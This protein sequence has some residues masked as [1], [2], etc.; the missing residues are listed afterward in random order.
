MRGDEG[1]AFFLAIMLSLTLMEEE[2]RCHLAL[3][4]RVDVTSSTG[5]GVHPWDLGIL[6][7]SQANAA[8][9]LAID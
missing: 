2:L 8:V 3:G 5:N 9:V 7:V 1:P 6:N 4:R